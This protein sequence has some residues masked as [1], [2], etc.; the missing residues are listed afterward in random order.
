MFLAAVFALSEEPMRIS[1]SWP[2]P[3]DLKSGGA[4]GGG[5]GQCDMPRSNK[6]VG[7][8]PRRGLYHW[9]PKATV[10]EKVFC[11]GVRAPSSLRTCQ[12]NIQPQQ[13]TK[14]LSAAADDSVYVVMNGVLKSFQEP[15]A[16]TKAL[17]KNLF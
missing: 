10:V 13:E 8:S 6:V 11:C 5:R 14:K 1:T 15:Q 12:Q 2:T 7:L 9:A 3:E 17:V 16:V 4:G